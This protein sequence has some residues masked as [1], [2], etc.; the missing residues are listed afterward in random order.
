MKRLILS[1]IVVG[2]LL[3]PACSTPT[4]TTTTS[5]PTTTTTP[6]TTSEIPIPSD[7]KTYTSE[8]LF[9]ISYPPDW[10]P[11]LPITE[12]FELLAKEEL[13]TIIESDLPI[14]ESSPVLE[15]PNVFFADVP[16]EEGDNPYVAIVVGDPPSTGRLDNV[17]EEM[18]SGAKGNPAA[19]YNEFSRVKTTVGGREAVIIDHHG[20]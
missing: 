20:W 18:I 8:G 12:M 16:T 6:T 13:I 4:T 9:S 10:E 15:F 1:V 11:S 17:V 7:Y 3:L 19:E 14:V 2:V 5:T